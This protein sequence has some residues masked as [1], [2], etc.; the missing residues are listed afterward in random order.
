MTTKI[1]KFRSL[2]DISAPGQPSIMVGEI[3][4][5]TEEGTPIVKFV[6][7]PIE[8]VAAR[9]AVSPHEVMSSEE[10][11]NNQV[12]ILFQDRDLEKPII[13]GIIRNSIFENTGISTLDPHKQPT[14]SFT[15]NGKKLVFEGEEEIVLR[16]GLGSITLRANGQISVKGSKLLSRASQSN[17]IRGA[18]VFIN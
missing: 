5:I 14:Q 11:I 7:A 16:C 6:G 12:V 8:G 10:L 2:N 13:T 17:K 3:I 15:V 1:S 4:K 9:I 18:S